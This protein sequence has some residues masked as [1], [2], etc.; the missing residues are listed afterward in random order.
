MRLE[1]FLVDGFRNYGRV[2]LTFSPGLNL[3]WGANAQGK[4]NLLEAVCYLGLA[5]SFRMAPDGELINYAKT[6]FYLRGQIQRQ[7]GPFVLEAAAGRGRRRKWKVDGQPQ[8]KLGEVVGLFHTVVFAPEDIWLVR[9]GPE[10]RRRYLN[11]LLAQTYRS[12]CRDQLQ[13]AHILRQRNACLKACRGDARLLDA[14]QLQLWDAQLAQ[15]GARIAYCREQ[16]VSRLAPLAAT[17]QDQLSAGEELILVY[18]NSAAGRSGARTVEEIQKHFLSE[19]ERLR[20]NEIVRGITL[21]GPHRDD[22]TIRLNQRFARDFAS[23]G[24]Q[25]TVALS[26]KLAELELVRQIRGEYPVLLLDDVLSELDQSRAAQVL[27]FVSGKGQ[28]FLSAV[29][30]HLAAPVGKRFQ[31]QA[32]TVVKETPRG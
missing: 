14:E 1:H 26:L 3:V 20:P 4:S 23:Q 19:L 29:D 18:A 24:Q 7:E 5:S 31:I 2:E 8:Q 28:T 27:E 6:Y 25:R 30:S 16:A 17:I 21:C 13:Y 32:G 22:L 15:T 9:S 12:Y 10:Q 11:R